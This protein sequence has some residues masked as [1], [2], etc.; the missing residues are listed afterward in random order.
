MGATIGEIRRILDGWDADPEAAKKKLIAAAAAR[1][2]RL[3]HVLLHPQDRIRRFHGSD[4]VAQNVAVDLITALQKVQPESPRH[5]LNLCARKVREAVQNLGRRCG[6]RQFEG[7]YHSNPNGQVASETGHDGRQPS[8]H[9]DSPSAIVDR[10]DFWEE[11]SEI[12]ERHLTETQREILDL[13]LFY[14]LN[15]SCVA[16]I[17]GRNE[18]TVRKHWNRIKI[19]LAPFFQRQGMATNDESRNS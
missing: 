16:E 1:L 15:A 12:V 2:R 14:E 13:M 18:S 7:L 9:S 19:K 5:F 8:A 17:L 10:N 3:A 11:F 4:D 6:G